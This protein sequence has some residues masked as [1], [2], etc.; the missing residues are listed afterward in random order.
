MTPIYKINLPNANVWAKLE[1]ENP[2]GTHKD[3]SIGPWIEYYAKQGVK[4]FAIA[5]S[6]NAAVSAARISARRG[7]E[8]N[9]FLSKNSYAIEVLEGESSTYKHIKIRFGQTS[10]KSAIQFCNKNKDIINLRASTDDIALIGY[11]QI[12][13][14]LAEQLPRIDNIF[15]PTSS[16]ATLEGVYL[17]FKE[18]TSKIPAFY[19]VQTTKVHPIASYF[20]KDFAREETSYATAIV[21]NIAHRRDKIIKICEET[22]GGGFVISRK[23]LRDADVIL[24]DIPHKWQSA[25][26]FAGFLTWQKKNIRKARKSV[27]V[28]LFT[29]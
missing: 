16:G 15:I 20:D 29:D 17:G 4:E 13:Y 2:T 21:D 14:E 8:L 5:S 24:R 10:R 1:N 28:C 27:S 19:A 12:S 6:G 23:E 18:K 11:K 26:A 7:L 3:R 22:G 25:L 9:I